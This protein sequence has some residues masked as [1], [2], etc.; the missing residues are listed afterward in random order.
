MA[1]LEI[2]KYELTRSDTVDQRG[3]RYRLEFEEERPLGLATVIFEE[4]PAVSGITA[5]ALEPLGLEQHDTVAEITSFFPNGLY[6]D[7]EKGNGYMR[8]GV[9]TRLLDLIIGDC[10]EESATALHVTTHVPMMQGFL[11]KHN[12]SVYELTGNLFYAMVKYLRQTRNL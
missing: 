6:Y 10:I 5:H 11:R 9:G 7:R 8:N 1:Q 4:L 3:F 2:P 12:F